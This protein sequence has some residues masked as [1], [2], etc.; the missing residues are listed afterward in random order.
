MKKSKKLSIIVVS[1]G[2]LLVV[3]AN[4]Y[5]DWINCSGPFPGTCTQ[6][7]CRDPQKA[8]DCKLIAC[9]N[10]PGNDVTCDPPPVH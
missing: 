9:M 10:M 8:E 2:L 7:G 6:G 5:A 3:G 1:L 4:I